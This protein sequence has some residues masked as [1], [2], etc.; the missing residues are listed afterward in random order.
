MPSREFQP[1]PKG[2][3]TVPAGISVKGVASGQQ[4]KQ[5]ISWNAWIFLWMR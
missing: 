2:L 4:V 3:T 1:L 5:Q